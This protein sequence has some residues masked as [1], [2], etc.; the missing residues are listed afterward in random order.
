MPSELTHCLPA[1]YFNKL[2]L[3]HL[4]LSKLLLSK[5]PVFPKLFHMTVPTLLFSLAD[6]LSVSLTAFARDNQISET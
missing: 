3:V 5:S 4:C 1:V 6:G 2:S